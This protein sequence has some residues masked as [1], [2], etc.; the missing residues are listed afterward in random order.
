MPKQYLQ[1]SDFSGGLNT[2]FDARDIKDDE[3]TNVSNLQVYKPGQLF[4]STASTTVISR[5]AG[6]LVAGY[7]IKLFRSD[8]DL[9]NSPLMLELLALADTNDSSDTKI[10][11]IEIIRNNYR[12][13]KFK[14]LF[15]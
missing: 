8:T 3:I 5:A 15:A 7:G 14:I 2:K 12:K 13:S 1:I 11:F 9:S 6:T 10:D 4:S